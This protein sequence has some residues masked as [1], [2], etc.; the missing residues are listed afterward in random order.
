[1]HHILEERHQQHQTRRQPRQ[2]I[3]GAQ[4]VEGQLRGLGADHA[5]GQQ[6]REGQADGH[7][8]DQLGCS[9]P[10]HEGG[11]LDALHA[12]ADHEQEAQQQVHGEVHIQEVVAEADGVG[13][14]LVGAEED[15]EI[16][17]VD[18]QEQTQ[19]YGADA[20]D[21]GHDQTLQDALADAVGVPGT[22]ILGGEAG[23]GGA[24]A[25]HRGHDE[26]IEFVGGA[27]AVLGGVGHHLAVDHIEL[28]HHALHDDDADGQHGE[29]EAQRHALNDVT[30][31]VQSGDVPVLL[32]EPQVRVLGKGIGK[33]GHGADE[34]GG[35]GGSGHAPAQH[36]NEQQIQCHIQHRGAQQEQQRRYGVAHA[37]QEGAD[38]VIKQLGADAG[39]DDAAVG[40]GGPVY[41]RVL[42]RHVDPGQH[43]VQQH[44]RQSCQQHRQPRRQHQLGGHGAA[45]TGLIPAAHAAGGD[46]AEPGADAEGELQEDEHQRGGVVDAGH[47]L[48][49]Q[50]LAHD[51]GVADGIH[52]LQQVRQDHRQ[53]ELQNGAPAG[54]V[55]QVHRVEQVTKGLK[56]FSILR[57][58]HSLRSFLSL[59]LR[60]QI[61]ACWAAEVKW[62]RDCKLHK[63][64]HFNLKRGIQID[65]MHK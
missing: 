21:G 8:G 49:R 44:Q 42:R 31:Q 2:R 57:F 24:K 4:G 40:V 1:M 36:Q 29:L 53:G 11:S 47:L 17:A 14:D 50:G 9:G 48:R 55:G 22:Q 37:P 32:V 7:T 45:H 62:R 35:D 25:V 46:D 13:G 60:R 65:E 52:L 20:D 54:A 43:G 56:R 41:L 6:G 5:A 16:C 12:V 30:L 59:F 64:R 58:L 34:L 61:I 15:V 28:H 19:P 39:E 51:G 18:G 38:E 26:A 10:Q 27:E 3:G 23:H 33:A 63:L